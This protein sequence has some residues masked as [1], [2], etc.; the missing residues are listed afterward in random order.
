MQ[1]SFPT[2]A[3]GYQSQECPSCGQRF[4][5]LFGG[6]SEEPI[7]FC[8]YC[9]HKEGDCWYTQDQVEYIQAVTADV[10]LGPELKRLE[11]EMKR[12]SGGFLKIDIKTELP[13]AGSPPM[14]TDETL[15]ILHFLCCNETVKLTRH[16]RHFC[17]ICGKEMDM[18]AS[19][20]TKVFLSHK[21]IDKEKV[22]EFKS[23]LELLGYDPWL[24]EDAMPAG[25]HW[26]A[27]SCRAC[28]TLAEL[29]SSSPLRSRMKDIYEPRSTTQSKRNERKATDS[30]SSRYNSLM[31]TA[32]WVRYQN[33]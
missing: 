3:D 26:N 4:K 10:V 13:E 31:L 12:A 8:P 29:C 9:G 20:L 7:Q 28:G 19:E 1:T 14:E 16:E 30:L 2:D 17:I 18:A 25:L 24:D 15:D 6:G 5:V 27:A 11:R 33:C 23:T 32:R 21:G 22:T